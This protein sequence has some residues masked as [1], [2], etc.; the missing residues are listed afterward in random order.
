MSPEKVVSTILMVEAI[1]WVVC[2]LLFFGHGVWLVVSQKWA[3]PR[4]DSA[5][6]ALISALAGAKLSPTD[7]RALRSLP[8]VLQIRLF[9]AVTS[10]VT[11][12]Y[13]ENLRTVAGT[14]GLLGQSQEACRSRLW[15]R[16]LQGA[17]VLTLFDTGEEAMM[18]LFNDK[19][20]VVRAQAAEWAAHH[21]TLDVVERMLGLLAHDSGFP[22]FTVQDSLLRM[23]RAAVDPLVT[24]LAVCT[25]PAAEVG[26]AVAIGLAEARFL[27]VAL[28]RC[29][30]ESPQVRSLALTLLGAIGARRGVEVVVGA[31]RDPVPEV[32]SAAAEVLGN[33]RHWP[34]T[35]LIAPLLRDPSWIVRHAAGNALRSL[36][37]PGILYLR[38]YLSDDDRFAADTARQVLDLLELSRLNDAS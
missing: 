37:A 30:D 14:L 36:D 23:G 17:R 2:T 16:R 3:R 1:V 26:L 11:G 25:G 24:Y 31:L 35:P 32:R 21:P 27:P 22:R 9:V 10:S 33:L 15:R 18:P 34:A 5:R 38:R 8:Q 19:E 28:I 12:V 7:I 4:V 6:A 13:R 20:A 29:R